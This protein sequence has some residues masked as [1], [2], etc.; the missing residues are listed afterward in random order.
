MSVTANDKSLG[1][2]HHGIRMIE[3][4]LTPSDTN[5]LPIVVPG[6]T[7][8]TVHAIMLSGPGSWGAGTQIYIQGSNAVENEG[9]NDWFRMRDG[10][11]TE[12]TLTSSVTG[13]VLME[14]PYYIRPYLNA[15]TGYNLLIR[16]ICRAPRI[17]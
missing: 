15:G 2:R 16:L 3:W 11:H 6:Y 5:M 12:I 4:I 8:K 13:C 7:D 9:Y 10:S 14:S 1:E 17:R